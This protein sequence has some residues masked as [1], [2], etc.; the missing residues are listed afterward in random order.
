[1]NLILSNYLNARHFADRLLHLE[2]GHLSSLSHLSSNT[3]KEVLINYALD[4]V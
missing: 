1:M 4:K 2:D 3:K